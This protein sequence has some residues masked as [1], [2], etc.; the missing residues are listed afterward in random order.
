MS[1][2]SLSV[3]MIVL[4]HEPNQSVQDSECNAV[5][6]QEVVP[7]VH[8]GGQHRNVQSH[9][10]HQ[11]HCCKYIWNISTCTLYDLATVGF[12]FSLIQQDLIP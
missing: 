5:P 10:S 8:C 6:A 3:T 1:N 9:T 11:G 7:K 2:V 12:F 4:C